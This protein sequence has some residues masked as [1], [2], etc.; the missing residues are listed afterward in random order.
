M[1]S[2]NPSPASRLRLLAVPAIPFALSLAL[3]LSSVG[4]NVHWQ[5]S[6]YY[7]AAIKEMGVLY[8][9]GF[10]VYQAL[11]KLWTLLFFFLDFVLA[12][13]LF[14]S[15]CAA[16]AAAA[17]A[18]AA[19]ELFSAKGALFRTAPNDDPRL[20]DFCAVA[21]GCLAA[22]GYTFWFSGIFAKGYAFYYL[23]LALL[24]WRMIRADSTGSRRDF[25]I[26]AA[27][28]GLA[29]Q[30][31]PSATLTGA[32]LL[33]FVFAHRRAL[34]WKGIAW[35]IGLAAAIAAGPVFLLPFIANPDA[36]VS[37]SDFRSL[38]DFREFL[39]GE[40]F[41]GQGTNF[42]LEASRIS[43]VGQFLWEEMLGV[44][45][46]AATFGLVRLV[47]LNRKLLLGAVAWIVPV[48]VITVYFRIEGQH[49]HWFVAA[50][51]PLYLAGGLGLR[52]LAQFA[53]SAKRAIVA[54]AAAAGV[55]WSVAANY[56]LVEQRTYDLAEIYGKMYLE[57]LER[58][59]I[60]L[61]ATDDAVSI[62]RYLQAVRGIR[63]DVVLLHGLGVREDGRT[64]RPHRA[65]LR[66]MERHPFL[67]APDFEGMRRR[68][69]GAPPPAAFLQAHAASGRPIYLEG[70]L[71][72]S[73]LPSG[74]ALVRA[75]P[76]VKLVP[77]AKASVDASD[78]PVPVEAGEIRLRRK[79]GQR[80]SISEG[81]MVIRP[82]AYEER[83]LL[84]LLRARADR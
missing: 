8:P 25:T 54:G 65:Y 26:V 52:E 20:A 80:V 9:P 53:G 45:L 43:S 22:S 17:L 4:S 14:S 18:V 77:A 39:F 38:K 11:C 10:V 37:F 64:G 35:R 34:G 69:P 16:L 5:D 44:G 40:R 68:H 28:I 57:P 50:W 33:L 2:E 66:M 70:P 6:G 75:G 84:L 1:S 83:L 32:A 76:F 74:H 23:V 61:V 49:D 29:W 78:W 71:P 73:V 51:L 67:K 13:H 56:A 42:G 82:E 58:D 12:V 79:R 27:L 81:E 60:I 48:L 63:T 7:L 36:A 19:R 62:C 30:A 59:A 21:A 31:H 24:L 55:L 41:T 15:F 72:A 3:S 46:I 47:R